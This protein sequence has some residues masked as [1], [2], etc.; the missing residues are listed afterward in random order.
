MNCPEASELVPRFFDAELEARMMRD[1]ALHLTRCNDCEA[2]V[3]RLEGNPHLAHGL[4]QV[5]TGLFRRHRRRSIR[6]FCVAARVARIL[7]RVARIRRDDPVK[8]L[9]V[10]FQL[11]NFTH[12]FVAQSGQSE[13]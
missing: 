1:V 4:I 9:R 5:R 7:R 3:R 2:E 10:F 12:F 11:P 13:I 8:T 6:S